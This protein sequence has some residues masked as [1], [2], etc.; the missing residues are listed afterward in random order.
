M[1]PFERHVPM[2][3]VRAPGE[4]VHPV[5]LFLTS[6]FVRFACVGGFGVIVHM[7]VVA[8]LHLVFSMQFAASQA[9][10]TITA[11]T[12]NFF[13]NNRITFGD[14]QLKRTRLLVGLA[15][16]YALCGVGAAANVAAANF[17]F[18]NG[19]P[20]AIASVAGILISAVWN[21]TT[22]AA[23]VWRKRSGVRV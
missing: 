21:F 15:T 14:V 3:P 12:V 9:I 22:S 19:A 5:R 4:T 16:F 18:R 2:I 20:W 13:A 1:Q 17:L 10:A 7:A 11:M 8:L 23:L 6:R